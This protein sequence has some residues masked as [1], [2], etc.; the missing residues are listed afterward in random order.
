MPASRRAGVKFQSTPS[1]RRATA[2]R[3]A[4][5]HRQIRFQSTP[6]ARRATRILAI[7]HDPT[8]F[9]STPSARRATVTI[10]ARSMQRGISIH[11]LREEGDPPSHAT[12]QCGTISIHALREEGDPCCRGGDGRH[13]KF[14]ST[15]SARRATLKQKSEQDNMEISIH[16]LREEGD[17]R[18]K[19]LAEPIIKFQ[20]TPSAR[21]ATDK[22]LAKL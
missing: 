14:Q 10:L 21:R 2:S 16:A 12:H 5:Q 13:M 18:L 20:S 7:S 1:A 3:H 17:D 19:V 4:E 6:S 11:A 9:Q 15:P 8:I 22:Y